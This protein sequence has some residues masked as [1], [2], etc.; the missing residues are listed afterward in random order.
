MSTNEKVITGKKTLKHK[1]L[2]N[3][4]D[5]QG[6]LKIKVTMLHVGEKGLT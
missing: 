2:K 4:V 1:L 5:Y 3:I 6:Y